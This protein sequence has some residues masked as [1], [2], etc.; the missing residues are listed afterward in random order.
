MNSFVASQITLGSFHRC[1]FL[2]TPSISRTKAA[3]INLEQKEY[4]IQNSNQ[5]NSKLNKF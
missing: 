2:G 4:L 3:K 1:T 5:V